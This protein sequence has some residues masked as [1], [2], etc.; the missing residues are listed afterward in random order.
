MVL[1]DFL[2]RAG[3]HAGRG[4]TGLAVACLHLVLRFGDLLPIE[5]HRLVRAALSL[6]WQALVVARAGLAGRDL[7]LVW[8]L[9]THQPPPVECEGGVFQVPCP[10]EE[11]AKV[12]KCE[13]AKVRK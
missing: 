10:G 5:V 3:M 2:P 13:S 9:P 7:V 1:A 12:R 4:L 8:T 11:S 6:L